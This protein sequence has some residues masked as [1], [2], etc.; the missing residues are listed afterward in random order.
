MK[1]GLRQR[2][3]SLSRPR[4]GSDFEFAEWRLA[5]MTQ[6]PFLAMAAGLAGLA[7]VHARTHHEFL[8]FSDLEEL[9]DDWTPPPARSPTEPDG[10]WVPQACTLPAS[11]RA[12]RSGSDSH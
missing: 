4:D 7:A 3:A 10:P 12:L 8:V 5:G 2:R 6:G 11:D 9:R 1:T